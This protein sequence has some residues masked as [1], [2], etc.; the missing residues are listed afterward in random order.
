MARLKGDVYLI[1]AGVAAL[2]VI[3]PL[4][5]LH[6]RIGAV[7]LAVIGA[8]VVGWLLYQN[9]IRARS[10][11]RRFETDAI[12]A[13]SGRHSRPENATVIKARY[14]SRP[15]YMELL[16]NLQIFGESFLLALESKNPE[17]AKGRFKTAMDLYASAV[18]SK[19]AFP[20][21][22][23]WAELEARKLRLVEEFPNAWRTNAAAA[24]L[25][26]AEGLKTDSAKRKRWEQVVALLADQGPA[27]SP[28]IAEMRARTEALIAL[29]RTPHDQ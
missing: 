25:S 14:R 23:I 22:V 6:E 1:A 27:A 19:A 20:S 10:L 4:V 9:H 16:R 8:S 15:Q 2:V 24:L 12:H 17:T 7:G 13:M 26:E 3:S 18:N 28:K 29:T 5:W 21:A 11:Q